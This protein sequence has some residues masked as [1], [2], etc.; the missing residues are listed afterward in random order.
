MDTQL[1]Y[2]WILG[3]LSFAGLQIIC[4]RHI[5]RY[6]ALS[7]LGKA[8][9]FASF[10]SASGCAW[11]IY[12]ID[13]SLFLAL[14]SGVCVGFF[15]LLSI[16]IYLLS[17]YS[18]IE[19]S[20]TLRLFSMIG[21]SGKSGISYRKI[22]TEYGVVAIVERRIKRFLAADVIRFN[23][24]TYKAVDKIGVFHLRERLVDVLDILFK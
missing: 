3:I 1:I 21:K 24:K 11:G 7:W 14:F 13:N 18:Y 9:G 12:R 16:V 8:G 6:H 20:V 4:L 22:R 2:F 5:P 17:V 23:G 19:S 15:V 10:V